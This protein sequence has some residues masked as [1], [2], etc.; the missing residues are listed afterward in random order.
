MARQYR[1]SQPKPSLTEEAR[2][3]F[4]QANFA[5]E[6]KRYADASNLYEAGLRLCPWW[7]EG[8]F[9]RAM[10]LTIK[11]LSD[12]REAVREMKKYLMLAPD[13]RDAQDKIYLWESMI[14]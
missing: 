10:I 3:L 8:H 1:E 11:E 5:V 14:K 7:P 12:Y 4:V 9:N 6:Q 2:R 13:A